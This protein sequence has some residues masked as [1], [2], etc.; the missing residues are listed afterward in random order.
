MAEIIFQNEKVTLTFDESVPCIIWTPVGVIRGDIFKDP[1][2]A[3]MDFIEASVKRYPKINWLNDAR[4]FKNTG[5]EDLLW[6]NK[7]VNDR[8]YK[9]GTQRVAFVLPNNIFGKWAIKTY[10]DFTNQR[11]DNKLDIKAFSDIEEAKFW[12]KEGKTTHDVS[13]I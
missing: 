11:S 2:K 13:F 10:V 5:R 1:F 8:A 6:L 4:K 3:G 9:L 7:N 12:L